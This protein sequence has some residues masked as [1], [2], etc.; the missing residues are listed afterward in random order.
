MEIDT[1]GAVDFQA[2]NVDT[3]GTIEGG[4]ITEGGNAVW[5]ATETDILNS[6]HYIAGSIDLEHMS[7]QSVDSDN[8]VNETIVAADIDDGAYNY[9]YTFLAA[10]GVLD[11][12]A[13]PTITIRESTGTGTPRF[14]VATFAA[15][16]DDVIYF[17]FVAPS[18]MASGN[19][20]AT[21]KWYADDVG[22]GETCQWGIDVSA[23]SEGDVDDMWEQACDSANTATEDVNTT[24]AT[25]LISTDI[26][27]S[28][29]DSVSAGDSVTLRFYRDVSGDDD[30][31]SSA[32]VKEVLISIPRT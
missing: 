7:S 9:N 14:R 29:L 30:L 22:A 15:D 17:S 11:D 16:A 27:M 10:T 25:R 23:T 26:T 28:N 13:P 18:E 2:G 31:S 8:I 24:E 19:W 5:N 6:I 32:D 12:D 1:S 21:V 20:T 4:T 3:D